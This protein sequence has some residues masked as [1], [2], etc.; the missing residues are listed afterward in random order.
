MSDDPWSDGEWHEGK[1]LPEDDD[2]EEY[3][4][5]WAPVIMTGIIAVTVILI[6][7]ICGDTVTTAVTAIWG[8]S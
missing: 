7:L 3:A 4:S 8:K 6:C 2:D 1:V 5:E